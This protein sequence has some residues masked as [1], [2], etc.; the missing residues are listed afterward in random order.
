[1]KQSIDYEYEEVNDDFVIYRS[2]HQIKK[3]NKMNMKLKGV[4][5]SEGHLWVCKFTGK[6]RNYQFIH[7]LPLYRNI[8]QYF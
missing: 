1:M 7:N 3:Q 8:F 4:T 6:S 2:K 5:A